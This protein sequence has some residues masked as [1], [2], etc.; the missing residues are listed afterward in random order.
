VSDPRRWL[1]Q[2]DPELSVERELLAAG[3]RLNPPAGAADRGWSGV[4]ASLARGPTDPSGGGGAAAG[5]DSSALAGGSAGASAISAVAL[6]AF[7]FGA[8]VGIGVMGLVQLARL[9][10]PDEPQREGRAHRAPPS[11]AAT[12]AAPRADQHIASRDPLLVTPPPPRPRSTVAVSAP[13]AMTKE[14]A[15]PAAQP[16][17]TASAPALAS[18]IDEPPPMPPAL[19]AA[20]PVAS[21]SGAAEGS[22]GGLPGGEGPSK[23]VSQNSLQVE[24]LELAQAKNLLAVGR[25]AEALVLLERSGLLF[26]AGSLVPEREALTIEALLRNGQSQ[27]ARERARAFIRRY[28][29][30]PISER[31]RALAGNP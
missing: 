5:S 28:P 6:K 10:S 3:K 4:A 24:A 16:S 8:V 2:L 13:V 11:E 19:S 20:A 26:A 25:S 7:M 9:S 23:K 30:S 1:D 27:R 21:A 29:G 31:L 18:S 15:E 14:Q 17:A 22:E 12:G